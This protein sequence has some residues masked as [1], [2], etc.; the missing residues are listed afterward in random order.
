MTSL[1]ALMTATDR[2]HPIVRTVP[3]VSRA[4]LEAVGASLGWRVVAVDTTPDDDKRS[5]LA[6][7]AAAFG[8]AEWFGL[9]LDALADSLSDVVDEPGVLLVWAGSEGFA[10]RDPAS[11]AGIVSVLRDRDADHAVGRLVTVLTSTA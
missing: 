5:V 11:F 7:L 6:A 2:R 9:N 8:F 10:R 4:D 3:N 1:R